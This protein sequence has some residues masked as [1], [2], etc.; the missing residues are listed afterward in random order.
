MFKTTRFLNT[1]FLFAGG[2]QVPVE[3]R[4]RPDLPR[5]PGRGGRLRVLRQEAA[6]HALLRAKLLRRV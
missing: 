2:R 5:S 4:V 3:A 1:L 6:R